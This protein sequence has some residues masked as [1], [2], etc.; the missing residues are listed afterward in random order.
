MVVLLMAVL[1]GCGSTAASPSTTLTSDETSDGP[2]VPVYN[3]CTTVSS[4]EQS[5]GNI[6]VL[7][8]FSGINGANPWGSLTLVDNQLYGRTR[9]GGA[10]DNGVVFTLA[11]DGSGMTDLY[12]FTAGKDNGTGNQPHH[13]ALL[14]NNGLL[15][16][17]TLR[18]GTGNN[19]VAFSLTTSSD[20]AYAVL[21]RF[22]GHPDD[23]AEAHSGFL[24]LS[25]RLY[26]MT[27][28]GGAH[29]KGTIFSMNLDGSDYHMLY[30]FTKAT[31][32]EP[33]GRL[34]VGSDGH[35]LFGMTRLGGKSD[36]GVIFTFDPATSKY[37]VIHEFTGGAAD[38]ALP[39][40]GYLTLSDDQFVGVTTKGGSADQG[41]AF[42]LHQD[43]SGFH[44]LHT[45]GSTANDGTYPKGS[46]TLSNGYL[47]GTTFAGGKEGDGTVFRIADQGDSYDR[48]GYFGGSQ[49]GA[50]PFDNVV[51]SADGNTLY[52]MTGAG[53]ADDPDCHKTYGTI[54]SVDVRAGL[55]AQL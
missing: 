7:Q 35:T 11:T 24:L 21:H 34:T 47:Y 46:L 12:S 44:L 1:A 37:S 43:G 5:A 20:H 10:S 15:Y 38:G 4:A 3:S 9:I 52:G 17:V 36:D 26:G 2:G 51:V 22:A 45:F 30:S 16:E 19:G 41:T 23:G 18:G 32:D 50:Y 27:A 29:D 25:N 42:A 49:T 53:G 8:P 55:A 14:Y 31:G 13:D 33:H 6:H 39:F 54:F 40:H 48:L 28:D